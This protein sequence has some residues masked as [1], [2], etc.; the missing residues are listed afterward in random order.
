MP[1]NGNN[2]NK[3]VTRNRHAYHENNLNHRKHRNKLGLEVKLEGE[4]QG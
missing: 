2:A 1:R 3:E 4:E